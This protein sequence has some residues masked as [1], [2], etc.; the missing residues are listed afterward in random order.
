MTQ[1]IESVDRS[2]ALDA[3]VQ[4]KQKTLT[5]DEKSHY[6]NY[7]YSPYTGTR[8]NEL[9]PKEQK[10]RN[11]GIVSTGIVFVAVVAPL[12]ILASFH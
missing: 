12:L 5:A 11:A 3:D 1:T 4:A 7:L 10:L 9:T 8:K 2:F 6:A